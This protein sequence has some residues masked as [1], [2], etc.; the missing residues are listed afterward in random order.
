MHDAA[1]ELL[2][3]LG[4]S[5]PGLPIDRDAVLFGAATHDLGKVL[6]KGEIHGK[7]DLHERDGPNLLV[8]LGVSLHLARFAGT[9][10]TWSSSC[11]LEDLLVTLADQVWKG[12]REEAVASLVAERI[13]QHTGQSPW[14]AYMRLDDLLNDVASRSIQRLSYS[15]N[16]AAH[17]GDGNEGLG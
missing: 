16:G 12:R 3:G 14:Q 15:L 1:L 7:G 11:D 5:F 17:Q 2:Q 8:S 13:A 9:H 6:H 10:G 4:A